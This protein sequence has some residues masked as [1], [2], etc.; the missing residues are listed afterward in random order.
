MHLT[1]AQWIAQILG[2]ITI[3]ISVMIPHMKTKIRLLSLNLVCNVVQLSEFAVIGAL[4]GIAGDISATIRVLVL[5]VFAKK[6]KRAPVW[7]LF[8]LITAHIIIIAVEW[9]GWLSVL[10]ILPIASIYGQWQEKMQII[11]ITAIITSVGFGTYSLLSGA[12]T[13]AINDLMIITSTSFALWK[14]RKCHAE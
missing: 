3:I 13:G 9:Q 7:I 10:M 5:F 11:R 2:V 6:C 4:T 14:F 1:S 8:A 12:Y